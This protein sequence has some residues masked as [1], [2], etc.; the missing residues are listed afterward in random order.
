VHLVDV[1]RY[2]VKSL[3]GERLAR[4]EVVA[5]GVAGDRQ[6]AVRSEDSGLVLS[7]K[8]EGRLL[9]ARASRRA[10]GPLAGTVEIV[11]P[12]GEVVTGLGPT[13]DA[14][15]S[16]WLGRG[17]RLVEAEP[18]AIPTFESQEQAD[19]DTSA[20][21]TW[22]GHPGRFVDSSPVHLLTTA[23]LRAM[24]AARPDLDWSVE[25]FRPNLLV[26]VAGDER[27]EDAWVGR[28]IAVG[29]TELEVVSPCARCVMVTRAQPATGGDLERQLGVLSYLSHV[30]EGT[31]GVLARVVRAGFVQSGDAVT[32]T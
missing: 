32:L 4:S 19:D 16:T 29:D 23:S 14:A 3:Q 28:R 22:D 1:W 13:S 30:A 21:V 31:I 12:T 26:E 9:S 24:V 27:S 8:R 6:Y 20:S 25:R 17:V 15:L 2:P 10:D 5:D 7:A 11:L 18:E